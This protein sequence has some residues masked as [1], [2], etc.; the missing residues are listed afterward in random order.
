M[1]KAE[2][3]KR[4]S[5]IEKKLHDLKQ[6]LPAENLYS[7][8][9]IARLAGVDRQR[10]RDKLPQPTHLIGKRYYYLESE[11]EGLLERLNRPRQ[12]NP[13]PEGYMSVATACEYM[14]F[15]VTAWRYRAKRGDIPR[16]SHMVNGRVYYTV[17]EVEKINAWWHAQ[18][19]TAPRGKRKKKAG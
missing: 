13:T 9:D 17:E 6:A 12:Y 19:Q 7:T 2:L 3:L 8:S 5:E 4:I 11:V 10:L 15:S 14:G 18:P 1:N 16:P